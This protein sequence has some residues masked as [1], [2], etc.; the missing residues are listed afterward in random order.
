MNHNELNIEYDAYVICDVDVRYSVI[1][2]Q[3][4]AVN[5]PR[6]PSLET[7]A[8]TMS[9]SKFL[10]FDVLVDVPVVVVMVDEVR[11]G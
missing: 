3:S 1:S 6:E 4:I 9:S 8:A 5:H 2:S 7:N 11:I 10:L